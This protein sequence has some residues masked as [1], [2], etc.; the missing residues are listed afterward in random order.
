[1]PLGVE[2]TFLTCCDKGKRH[3]S[4]TEKFTVQELFKQTKSKGEIVLFRCHV[5]NSKL[6]Q[7]PLEYARHGL[8]K[9]SLPATW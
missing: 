6:K 7:V 5:G 4:E 3:R 9:L 1:M 8:S 2:R